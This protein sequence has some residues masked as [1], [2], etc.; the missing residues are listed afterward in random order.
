[1]SL[2][3]MTPQYKQ[4]ARRRM[5]E[6]MLES[7]ASGQNYQVI[8]PVDVITREEN[9]TISAF[10]PGVSTENLNIE[11]V[12]DTVTIEG[13]IVI[14]RNEEDHYLLSE[15]P[16]GKF[17]RV[18]TL[19]SAVDADKTEAELQNGVLSLLVPKSELARPRKIKISN[20]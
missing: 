13:E 4:L 19:P 15:R 5:W 9:Y 10:L 3:Y 16:S 6:Q 11:I 1:M 12:D 18:I 7:K 2:Y 20:N 17:R 14:E 8:F